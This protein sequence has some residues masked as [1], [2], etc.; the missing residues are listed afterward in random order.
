MSKE[1]V[2]MVVPAADLKALWE[3]K[4][5]HHDV[6]A[7]EDIEK[8]KKMVQERGEKQLDLSKKDGED[9]LDR[10]S[11]NSSMYR[12]NGDD[13]ISNLR[14][15]ARDHMEN[16]IRARAAAYFVKAGDH[17]IPLHEWQDLGLAD[18]FGELLD[19]KKEKREEGQF[20]YVGN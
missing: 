4:A 9:L 2:I 14:R 7:E 1:S 15:S 10:M 3:L 13:P 5:K 12:G 6:E 20:P 19:Q 17:E 18:F 16:A 8:L 11:N